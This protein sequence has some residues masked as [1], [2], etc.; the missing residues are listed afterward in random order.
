M[1]LGTEHCYPKR[2]TCELLEDN[3]FI[4]IAVESPFSSL[5]L[6][7]HPVLG[8]SSATIARDSC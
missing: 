2:Q 4:D 5:G 8:N 7:L 6:R 3:W 1:R